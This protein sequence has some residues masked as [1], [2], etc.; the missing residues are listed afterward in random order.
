M[1]KDYNGSV[2]VKI[3]GIA[4]SAASVIAMAGDHI[5]ISP[6]GMLMIHNPAT[7]AM[8]DHNDMKSA[9]AML[10]EVKESIINAYEI[11]TGMSR[12]EI[13]ELMENETWMNA[14]KALELGFVDGIIGKDDDKEEEEPEKEP[15]EEPAEEEKEEPKADEQEE[16]EEKEPAKDQELT[17]GMAY[18]VRKFNNNLIDKLSKA[19]KSESGMT[20]RE[21][22]ELIG[23]YI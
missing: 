16:E 15:E 19:D 22:L 2:N 14:N 23:K 21:R 11:K 1:L 13:S 17:N 10:E 8:G 4:A 5:Q 7:I 20:A 9:I 6:L 18:S 3:D 12:D